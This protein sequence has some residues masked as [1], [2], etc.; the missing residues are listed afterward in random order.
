MG[1]ATEAFE[2]PKVNT[3]SAPYALYTSTTV[4]GVPYCPQSL[5]PSRLLPCAIKLSVLL[6]LTFTVIYRVGL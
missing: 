2:L 4:P 6:R 5:S 3:L 1:L